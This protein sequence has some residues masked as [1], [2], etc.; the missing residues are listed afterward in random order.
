[1]TGAWRYTTWADC[2]RHWHWFNAVGP[3]ERVRALLPACTRAG[4]LALP[5]LAGPAAGPL[6]AAPA[7]PAL[8]WIGA[9]GWVQAALPFGPGGYGFGPGGFGGGF[10][11]SPSDM[12]VPALGIAGSSAGLGG[13][14][15]DVG[16]HVVPSA[17]S[18]GSGQFSGN[19]DLLRVS[20]PSLSEEEG[21][22]PQPV[23]EA[24]ALAVVAVALL[25]LAMGRRRG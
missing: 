9:P 17:P 5:L 15:R 20:P 10:G 4:A 16:T 19:T 6:L 1:M 22:A 25:G 24:P 2:T 18:A 3:A 8:P 14:A 7:A 11:P 21:V 13:A 12:E 23:P